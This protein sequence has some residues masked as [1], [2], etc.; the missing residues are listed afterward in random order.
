MISLLTLTR[1]FRGTELTLFRLY[2]V[3]IFINASMMLRLY[4]THLSFILNSFYL[5]YRK[6]VFHTI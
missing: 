3:T 5:Y 6:K 4:S 1:F 2:C